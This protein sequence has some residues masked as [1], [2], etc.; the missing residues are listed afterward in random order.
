[1]DSAGN[2]YIADEVNHRIRKL[3]LSTGNITTVA[4]T[5]TSGYN[6]DNISA[7]SAQLMLPVGVTVDSSG[8]IYIADTGNHRIRMVSGATQTKFGISM[9]VNRIYTIAGTGLAS[10][11]GDGATGTSA[12]LSNPA[13]VSVDSAGNIYIADTGNNRIRKVDTDGIITTVAGAGG[14]SYDGE[15]SAT[16]KKL[17]IPTGVSVD[18]AGNIYIADT[19]NNRIRKVTAGTI[20]TLVG[21][22]SPGFSG[23]GG[24]AIDAQLNRPRGVTV[25]SSGDIYIADTNNNRIRKVTAGTITTL[26]ISAQLSL[27]NG[28]TVDSVGNIYIADLG[29]Q[30]IR[31]LPA[32]FVKERVAGTGFQGYS[33]DGGLAVQA[34]LKAARGVAVDTLGNVIVMDNEN[35]AIRYIPA[36]TGII[37]TICGTGVA[38]TGT[39]GVVGTASQ[40]R[41][42]WAVVF[43]DPSTAYFTDSENNTSRVLNLTGHY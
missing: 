32:A 42:P 29:N 4:G 31:M 40:V 34:T 25:D 33:G 26:A 43:K 18:S 3:T 14:G 17:N 12:R 30:R 6:G 13:G 28:V 15:G 39:N 5:D 27:P 21:T 37:H 10:Y 11:G 35:D 20:T 19:G 24:P 9:T 7:I 2:I 41:K 1:M 22:G 36:A 23:D 16:L 38:G 8:N